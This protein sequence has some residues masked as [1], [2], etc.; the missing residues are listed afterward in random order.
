MAS[1]TIRNLDERLKRELRIRAARHSRSM[2]D[3]VRN[4]LKMALS[5]D[6]SQ[7]HLA[8]SIRACFQELGGVSLE[9]PPRDAPREPPLLTPARKT[10]K[11]RTAKSRRAAK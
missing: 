6:A 2:E 4:I 1:I 5:E 8:Q 7:P 9:L 10:T 11:T 3:E